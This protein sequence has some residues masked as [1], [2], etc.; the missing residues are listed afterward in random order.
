MPLLFDIGVDLDQCGVQQLHI[1]LS[2]L[3]FALS[4]EQIR[5]FIYSVM[6][7]PSSSDSMP[8]LFAENIPDFVSGS[9]DGGDCSAAD[10]N[11]GMEL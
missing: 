5:R 11:H 4:V 9:M 7:T 6:Q 1:K 8:T 10:T 2:R 3:G